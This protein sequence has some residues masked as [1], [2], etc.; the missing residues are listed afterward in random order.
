MTT[1]HQR[2]VK[3][4]RKTRTCTWCG[5]PIEIGHPYQSYRWADGTESGTVLL[6]PECGDAMD[7]ACKRDPYLIWSHGDFLRGST[8]VR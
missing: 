5:E 1:F 8:K 3:R 7:Q 4:S 6:H 2:S